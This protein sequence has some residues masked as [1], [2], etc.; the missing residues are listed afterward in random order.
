M[1]EQPVVVWAHPADVR[2]EWQAY[3]DGVVKIR[4]LSSGRVEVAGMVEEEWEEV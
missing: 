3:I 1:A 2:V 4:R